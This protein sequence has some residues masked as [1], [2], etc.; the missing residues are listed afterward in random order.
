[1]IDTITTVVN[2]FMA[3]SKDIHGTETH[4][5][6]GR[7]IIVSR[8]KEIVWENLYFENV[9]FLMGGLHICFNFLKMIGQY[10]ECAGPDDLWTESGM[11]YMQPTQLGLNPFWMVQL[12][13]LLG[14]ERTK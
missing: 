2:R 1:M 12:Y 4:H 3:I 10:M 14:S 13:I 9:I 8:G 7:S 6:N 5:Y 11:H